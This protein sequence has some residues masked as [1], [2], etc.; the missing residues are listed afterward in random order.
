MLVL[1]SRIEVQLSDSRGRPLPTPDILIGLN[2]LVDGRYYYG[3]LVG[4]TNSH[5]TAA[6]SREELEQRF[7]VDQAR[8]PMDYKVP[9]DDCDPIIEVLVMSASEV[10]QARES[11]TAD[12]SISA[13]IRDAYERARNDEATPALARVWA[14]VADGERLLVTVVTGAP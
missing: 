13:E 4:L 7:K 14:N 1:P 2:L 10:A 3:N 11:V 9:L 12:Y 8:F 5:G 6:I